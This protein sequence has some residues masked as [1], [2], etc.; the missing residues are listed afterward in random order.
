MTTITL[1]TR[2]APARLTE[3]HPGRTF[4]GQGWHSQCLGGPPIDRHGIVTVLFACQRIPFLQFTLFSVKPET[5]ESAE[6]RL[7]GSTIG[8]PPHI[9][10][11]P[12]RHGEDQN[13]SGGRV[14][15]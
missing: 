11:V 12:Q 4:C 7:G 8:R 9:E 13:D 15:M 10:K 5:D 6:P 14:I 3:S 2:I 1:F